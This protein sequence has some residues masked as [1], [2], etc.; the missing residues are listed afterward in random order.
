MLG[1]KESSSAILSL[2]SDGRD[3][4]FVIDERGI[5]SFLSEDGK[6]W[7]V[8]ENS[9]TEREIYFCTHHCG[10]VGYEDASHF[11]LSA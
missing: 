8:C 2:T 9:V 6:L 5:V 3:T 11:P 10:V 4:I 1:P 7:Q